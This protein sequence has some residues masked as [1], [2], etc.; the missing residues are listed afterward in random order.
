MR[1]GPKVAATLIPMLRDPVPEVRWT[2]ASAL[3]RVGDPAALSPLTEVLADEFEE[4]RRQAALSLGYLGAGTAREALLE[5]SDRDPMAAV[6][7]AAA[8]AAS[9]LDAQDEP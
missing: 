7:E 5:L 1:G 3:G 4:V 8:Y 2:A 9:L 6:R